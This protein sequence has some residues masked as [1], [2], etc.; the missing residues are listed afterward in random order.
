M[1]RI[2]V[3]NWRNLFGK[4]LSQIVNNIIHLV[5]DVH[6]IYL[7]VCSVQRHI[8]KTYTIKEG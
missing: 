8:S 2:V 3:K 5:K 1:V 4:G 7:I 6:W